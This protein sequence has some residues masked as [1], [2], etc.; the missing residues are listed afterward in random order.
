[1]C[2]QF[3]NHPELRFIYRCII[4]SIFTLS[5]IAKF[6]NFSFYAL[7]LFTFSLPL[8]LCHQ[9]STINYPKLRIT[10]YLSSYYCRLKFLESNTFPSFFLSLPSP[11]SAK[12][13]WF[14]TFSSFDQLF[15]PGW[16]GP[17]IRRFVSLPRLEPFYR[18]F[19][20]SP[21]LSFFSSLL[22]TSALCFHA[23]PNFGLLLK[24]LPLVRLI[25]I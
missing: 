19:F 9:F 25:I 12:F 18:F 14:C 17:S 21:F 4:V 2:R 7:V 16:P 20:F 6:C 3:S 8:Q 13:R 23:N 1:M 5:F 11:L 22:A 10:V 24:F 15:T